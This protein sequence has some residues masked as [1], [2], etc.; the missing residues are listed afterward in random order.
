MSSS[1]ILKK[2][3]LLFKNQRFNYFWTFA[4]LL[5][6]FYVQSDAMIFSLNAKMRIV[7][8][9]ILFFAFIICCFRCFILK[10]KIID[11]GNK[12]FLKLLILISLF[13]IS[14]VFNISNTFNIHRYLIQVSNIALSYVIVCSLNL[15]T[16]KKQYV[17]MLCVFSTISLLFFVP[18]FVNE[19]AFSFFPTIQNSADYKFHFTGFSS[20]L[21]RTSSGLIKRNYGIFREPGIYGVFLIF[22]LLLTFFG[23]IEYKYSSL[24]VVFPSIL[25][26]T[27]FTTLSTTTIISAIILCFAKMF[28][29]KGNKALK[30][31]RLLLL[32]ALVVASIIVLFFPDFLKPIPVLYNVFGKFS[33]T[34]ESF[35]SRYFDTF[36]TFCAFLLNPVFGVGFG[37]LH[38]NLTNIASAFN[39]PTNGGINSIL[40]TFAVHGIIFGVL[41]FY[42]LFKCFVS[43]TNRKDV[44]LYL[45]FLS[46]LLCIFNEDICNSFFFFLIVFA[47]LSYTKEK[48]IRSNE[49]FYYV[50]I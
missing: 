23:N 12:L 29:I 1:N 2:M 5:I 21:I 4:I 8:F 6:L 19:N 18:Y 22:A 17:Y 41:V 43:A 31:S 30:I 24:K 46:F 37:G 3:Q 11:L 7:E 48:L 39:S 14:F 34:N 28:S 47:G 36:A 10:I 42:S 25:I 16:I 50:E 35:V 26:I 49:V 13:V 40:Q 45:I 32:V 33:F 9:A 44:Y 27:I 38:S 15:K 20:L